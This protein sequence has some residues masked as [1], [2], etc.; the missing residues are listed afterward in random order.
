MAR[1][2]I[3][4]ETTIYPIDPSAWRLWF[5]WCRYI[6]DDNTIQYGY[7][8][9]WRRP[10]ND[11]G[12]L[13]AARGQ[14]RIPSIAVMEQLIAKARVEGWGNKTDPDESHP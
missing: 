7:R 8:F 12:S 10:A 4:N 9:I 1:V 3:L 14:A 5:Q 11:G 13:Q 2:Q 6:Y